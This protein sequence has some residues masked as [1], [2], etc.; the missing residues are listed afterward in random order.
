[1]VK[2][3]TDPVSK[4]G[5][6]NLTAESNAEEKSTGKRVLVEIPQEDLPDDLVVSNPSWRNSLGNRFVIRAF[7]RGVLG[8]AGYAWGFQN[9]SKFLEG[10]KYDY[11]KSGSENLTAFRNNEKLNLTSTKGVARTIAQ[12]W[13]FGVDRVLGA[14]MHKLGKKV[15]PKDANSWA[16]FRNSSPKFKRGL[17]Q[18]IWG[19]TFDFAMSSTGDSIGDELVSIL[20]PN[21]KTSWL[22]DGKINWT[23]PWENRIDLKKLWKSTKESTW[24]ILSFR[25]G[26]DWAVSAAYV[27]ACRLIAHAQDK[28]TPGFKADFESI[29]RNGAS[30]QVDAQ[31]ATGE[32]GKVDVKDMK[33]VG[34][35]SDAGFTNL[36]SRFWLYNDLTRKYRESYKSWGLDDPLSVPKRVSES[37]GNWKEAG[38]KLPTLGD[39]ASGTV[40]KLRWGVG[41]S[42]K[43]ALNMIPAAAVFSA[44]RVQQRRDEGFVIDAKEGALYKV[45][46]DKIDGLEKGGVYSN[47]QLKDHFGDADKFRDAFKNTHKGEI[48]AYRIP[49]MLE[50]KD[51]LN[52]VPAD[53]KDYKIEAFNFKTEN[54]SK[55][56]S[57]F[58]E[59][60]A[61]SGKLQ[62]NAH[63]LVS[64]AMQK[65]PQSKLNKLH[66]EPKSFSREW[67]HASMAYFPYF[68]AKSDWIGPLAYSNKV[69][70]WVDKNILTPIF[71]E[72]KGE[73][74]IAKETLLKDSPIVEQTKS[75][76]FTPNDH[77]KAANS[78]EKD[79]NN[80][81]RDNAKN[82]KKDNYKKRILSK[83]KNSSLASRVSD[84][85][86]LALTYENSF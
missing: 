45:S 66:I 80:T 9:G 6:F 76:I 53:N 46:G 34:H 72:K 22:K 56:Q 65:L 27:Y 70:N 77:Q 51:R 69:D 14:G 4:N 83:D 62:Y 32:K 85:K 63:K 1:M 21:H 26:E 78:S 59:Y 58:E 23:K 73:K 8:A 40:A 52:E 68:F 35:Y 11:D 16:E 57:V 60:Q 38:F 2:G 13:A 42:I 54:R 25:Q 28:I 67:V 33:V 71:G 81:D 64:G 86:E 41:E 30:L 50:D 39:I 44:V 74:P 61:M 10:Y 43:T 37:F 17:S 47:K 12:S 29:N 48:S 3:I 36:W 31:A 24:H 82:E 5:L 49:D 75:S 79:L 7:T 55:S 18:E 84:E 19:V 15:G 20:D